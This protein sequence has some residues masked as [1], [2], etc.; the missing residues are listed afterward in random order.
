MRLVLSIYGICVEAFADQLETLQVLENLGRDFDYFRVESSTSD[1]NITLEIRSVS[2]D[3]NS[4]SI[5]PKL[6]Q[7]K[8]CTVYGWGPRRYCD[9]DHGVWVKA[10]NSPR[11]RSFTV[12]GKNTDLIYEAAYLALLSAIGEALDQRGFHRIHAVGFQLNGKSHVIAADSGL[13]KSAT[14]ILMMK[15]GHAKVFS[16]EMP[17]IS[18]GKVYPFP[19]R[20]ALHPQVAQSLGIDLS[21][22]REF[23]RKVYP[24]KALIEIDRNSVAPPSD[25]DHF[26]L[27]VSGETAL[28][29]PMS[30]R[31]K[32]GFL[33]SFVMGLGL[34]QMAEH[35]LRANN[36]FGLARIAFSRL[37]TAFQLLG[38]GNGRIQSQTFVLTPKPQANVQWLMKN[39]AIAQPTNSEAKLLSP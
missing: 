19:I 34:P 33:V 27:G 13:G 21:A 25:L 10:I 22:A 23:K 29:R 17:L 37:K 36:V 2:F 32:L 16:D 30:L 9:Y 38:W 4:A 6:F 28:A 12:Y 14:A 3:P 1:P 15:D 35:M 39:L 24:K 18:Q 11:H 7:T 8:M 31:E 5:G 26:F 20:M